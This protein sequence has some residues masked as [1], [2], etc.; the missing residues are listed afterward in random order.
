MSPNVLGEEFGDAIGEDDPLDLVFWRIAVR[1]SNS[2]G[3]IWTRMSHSNRE[4]SR[5][6][7]QGGAAPRRSPREEDRMG[8]PESSM[9]S[10]IQ[11]ALSMSLRPVA[12]LVS[13][14]AP[15]GAARFQEGKWGCVMMMFTAVATQGRCAAFDRSTYG[16]WGGGVGL[17]FGNAY[18][19]FPGGVEC[20]VRFLS[21]GNA[22][23]EHGRRLAA[24][25]PQGRGFSERFLEGERY[26]ASPALARAFVEQLPMREVPSRYVVFKPLADVEPERET[27]VTV[28]FPVNAHQLSA[29]VVLANAGRPGN[30]NVAIP[31]AAS[32]QTIGILPMREAD[33]PF[34]RAVVGHTDISARGYVRKTLGPEI[35]TFAAP[36][37]LFCEMEGLA[38]E[39]FLSLS[40]WGVLA[41]L[42]EVR[43]TPAEGSR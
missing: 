1:D 17:G 10:K 31:F 38:A 42:T 40:T 15:A 34:P 4:Q 3:S 29:L 7:S 9:Q 28:V 6:S 37:A 35:V 18:E 11:K 24:T 21:T 33:R 25:L 27:P 20:F 32:C 13:E 39:S 26:I 22:G 2:G 23:W 43:K 14:E 5:S 30:E 36:W 8:S 16:C 19:T 12:I 41:E